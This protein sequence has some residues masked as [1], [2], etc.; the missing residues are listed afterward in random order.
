MQV[1]I[2]IPTYN[3]KEN[4]TKLIGNVRRA[5]S[6]KD[7]SLQFVIVDDN[8]PDG[9]ADIVNELA[10]R[11]PNIKLLSRSGKLGLGSA[12]LH[13]FNWIL[14]NRNTDLTDIVIQMDA[15]LSHPPE[16]IEKMIKPLSNDEADVIVA[17]RYS[18]G[19][20]SENWPLHRKLISK[21][22]NLLSTSLL[23]IKVKDMTSGYRAFKLNVI[24]QL[25]SVQLSGKG[26]EYQ[27]ESLYAASKMG[28]KIKEIPFLFSNRIGGKSKLTIKDMIAF[29]GIIVNLKVK[30]SP[31]SYKVKPEK[32]MQKSTME[33]SQPKNKSQIF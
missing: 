28:N 9:T 20:S 22:A 25:L 12:Y 4:I 16:L 5:V 26:Y 8:S 11:E 2:V 18:G 31:Y 23:G 15:D 6:D 3:E 10:I 1:A 33:Y 21:V 17:S 27:I 14:N 13:G 32:Q 7:V 19:G 30:P 24:R 29:I